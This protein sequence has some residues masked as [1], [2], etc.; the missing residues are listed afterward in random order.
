MTD[1]VVL[2]EHGLTHHQTGPLRSAGHDTAEAV[3]D[4][5]DAHRATVARSTLAQLPGM[6]PR[7]L[8]LVCTAVDSWRA[9]IS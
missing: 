1:L 6:G 3:A 2:H 7:R 4:L 9:V 8:A 5:V